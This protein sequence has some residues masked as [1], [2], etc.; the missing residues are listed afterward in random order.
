[1]NNRIRQIPVAISLLFIIIIII[2][3]RFVLIGAFILSSLDLRL[4][5]LPEHGASLMWER[6]FENKL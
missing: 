5:G 3:I 2:I 1:M 4:V 6:N